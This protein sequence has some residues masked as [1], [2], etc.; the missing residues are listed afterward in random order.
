VYIDGSHTADDV[1]ADAVLAWGLLRDGGYMLFDDYAWSGRLKLGEAATPDELRPGVAIDAFVT[2][3]RNYLEVVSR[4]WQ[5]VVRKHG[6]MCAFKEAC[7]PIGEYEYRWW[8]G[9]LVRRSD[10]LKMQLTDSERGV[11]EA[12]LRSRRFGQASY[13]PDAALKADP[14]FAPLVSRLGLKL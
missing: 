2:A 12:L 14:A 11:L 1:L 7:S 9:E 6:G 8:T 4:D 13:E 5:L 3:Y 10:N